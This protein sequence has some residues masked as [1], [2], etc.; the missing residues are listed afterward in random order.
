MAMF[1]LESI[2]I[3]ADQWFGSLAAPLSRAAS[4]SMVPTFAVA[5]LIT[6]VPLFLYCRNLDRT[7]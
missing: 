4:M 2:G 5:A 6:A 1:V 3:A 7:L